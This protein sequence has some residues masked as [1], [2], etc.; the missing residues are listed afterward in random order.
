[1]STSIFLSKQN[2][3][4]IWDVLMDE[5]I[6]KNKSNETLSKINNMFNSLIVPF[7]ENE[8]QITNNLFELNKKFITTIIQN[9]NKNF[10][11]KIEKIKNSEELI[12][13]EDLQSQRLI[14]FDN[15]LAKKQQ[16]FENAITLKVPELPNFKD[17]TNDGPLTEIEK[18]VKRM[19]EQR[20]YDVEQ[21][22]KT[23]NTEKVENWLTPSKTS[24][25]NEK[26]ILQKELTKENLIQQNVQNI[27]YIKIENDEIINNSIYTNDVI[28][29]TP[30]SQKKRISWSDENEN[31]KLNMNINNVEEQRQN[32]ESIFKKFKL[33]PSILSNNSEENNVSNVSNINNEIKNINDKLQEFDKKLNQILSLL[34]ES[35]K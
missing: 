16:E 33:V 22:S 34:T 23:F 9:V 6:L 32:A 17:E 12:T 11:R 3:K 19:M 29:L 20:N 24:I 21:I 15:Q 4:L 14:D 18:E 35:V 25:K 13:F 28:D 27:K 8:K 7:Y 2:V 5:D 26:N 10:E 30:Q 31:I 1:M